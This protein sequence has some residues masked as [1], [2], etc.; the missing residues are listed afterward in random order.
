MLHVGV[1]GLGRFIVVGHRGASA[2]EPENTLKSIRKAFSLGAD[3]VE[4]DVRVTFD[5]HLVVIHDERVDRVTGGRGYVADKTLEELMR[6]SV[7]GE[8]IPLLREVLEEA[9]RWRRTV[10]VE[11]VVEEIL[12]VGVED[13]VVISS[14]YHKVVA[15]VKRLNGR[16]R[17]GVIFSSQPVRPER[18][19]LDA[20]A[21]IIFPKHRFVDEEMVRGAHAKGLL[22]FPWT[23]DD[24]NTAK[25]LMQLK[26]D[27]IV[28][29]KPDVIANLKR[30][31]C[32]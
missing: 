15:A 30:A 16:I 7:G 18:L 2:Y 4:V 21:E 14:F 24:E 26:V 27:G 31:T 22:V 19:A 17:T 12:E 32:K 1:T 28:T 13:R 11:K 23:V 9:E 20:K 10:V 25:H 3:W 5:G 8:K 29:N 6:L